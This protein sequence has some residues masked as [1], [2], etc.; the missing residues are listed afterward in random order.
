MDRYLKHPS[1]IKLADLKNVDWDVIELRPTVDHKKL[2]EWYNT[3]SVELDQAKW[4]ACNEYEEKYFNPELKRRWWAANPNKYSNRAPFWWYMN[5][6]VE[7]YDPLPFAFLAN[8]EIFPEAYTD[9]YK[10]QLNPLLSRYNFGAFADLYQA[11]GK[12]L[13]AIRTIVLPEGAGLGLHVDMPYP[14][15][16]IRLHVQLDINKNCE[17]QFG[18]AADRKYVM[19]AGKMYLVNTAVPHSVANFGGPDWVTIYG[20][21]NEEDIDEILELV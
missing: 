12:Y 19:E 8:R 3:M 9:S 14:D 17:W 20:T 15:V 5:W 10:D 21:P 6:P 13:C 7:R 1:N 18:H 11:Y 2:M 16:I 4:I